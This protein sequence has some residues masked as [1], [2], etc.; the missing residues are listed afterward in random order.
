MHTSRKEGRKGVPSSSSFSPAA[1]TVVIRH[2]GAEMERQMLKETSSP[3]PSSP[4]QFSRQRKEGRKRVVQKKGVVVSSAACASAG[5]LNIRYLLTL[6]E[7]KRRGREGKRKKGEFSPSSPSL[8]FPYPN[9][10]KK[11]IKSTNFTNK[12]GKGRGEDWLMAPPAKKKGN[13]G[14]S[15]SVHEEKEERKGRL[16]R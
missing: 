3:S 12:R 8:P 1:P 15:H 16:W 13:S 2:I 14:Q 10:F 7:R 11:E 9:P 5:L 4:L 6:P